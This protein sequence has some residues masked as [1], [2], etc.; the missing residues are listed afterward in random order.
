MGEIDKSAVV[1]CPAGM[2]IAQPV[3]GRVQY[4]MS[5]TGALSS[6]HVGC[7]RSALLKIVSQKGMPF[8]MERDLTDRLD[9]AKSHEAR[10]AILEE[11]ASLSL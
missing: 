11:A 7:F 9:N 6:P 4:A 5:L 1:L 8:A 10:V 3:S 2:P